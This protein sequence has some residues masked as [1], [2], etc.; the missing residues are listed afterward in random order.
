[1][2][3]FYLFTFISSYENISTTHP[4]FL[5]VNDGHKIYRH[6]ILLKNLMPIHSNFSLCTHVTAFVYEKF[7][8]LLF[9]HTDCPLNIQI[10]LIYQVFRLNTE[11]NMSDFWAIVKLKMLVCVA[12]TVLFCT[13]LCIIFVFWN[14]NLQQMCCSRAFIFTWLNI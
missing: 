12:Q 13:I 4:P 6:I 2:N 3:R 10:I 11:Q 9:V 14:Q 8:F 7:T 1:M 5:T